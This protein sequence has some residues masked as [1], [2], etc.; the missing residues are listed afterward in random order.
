MKNLIKY[1]LLTIIFFVGGIVFYSCTDFEKD[2]EAELVKYAEITITDFTPKSGRPGQAVTITGSNFGEYSDAAKVYF[3]GVLATEIE[4]YTNNQMVVRVPNDAGTGLISVNVWTHVKDFIDEFTYI[5]GAKISSIS[6]SEGDVGDE[7]T[8]TGESFGTESSLVTIYFGGEVE[9][10][11]VSITDTEIVVKVPDGGIRG[12][13]TMEIGPQILTG[14]IFSYPFVGLN[15]DFNTDGESEGWV[16]SNNSTNEV[17]GGTMNVLYDM[18]ATKRRADFKLEGGA[19][20]HAGQF[21]IVAIR[22]INKPS[23]GNFIFDT[24]LGKYKDG[25]NNWEGILFGDIY[26]YDL[27]NTFGSGATLSTTEPTQLTTFQWK[28]ADITSDETGYSVDWVKTFENVDKLIEYANPPEGKYVFEFNDNPRTVTYD[29]LD[30][31]IGRHNATTIIEDDYAKVTFDPAQFEGD[32]KRRSDFTWS[33]AGGWGEPTQDFDKP[34]W[35]VSADYP[36]YAIKIYFVQADGTLGGPRPAN[37]KIFYDRLGDF[38]DDYVAENVLFLDATDW[39]GGEAK[40]E[41]DAWWSIKVPDIVSD[42][43]GYWV[44]WHRTF[45]NI[46]ELESFLGL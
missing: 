13:I 30:D 35:V 45:K 31:W 17:L 40:K 12:E 20:V 23:T 6:P 39:L 16:T 43:Q 34:A 22:M 37:G 24:N 32:N 8:I 4:S 10:E 41:V 25:S 5:P 1:I 9:A 36:I 46:E 2:Y 26:Y 18:S 21:P 11:I 28:V 42:E 44:D 7:I 3:N 38:S 15:F 29:V 14:P 33:M 27:R 19:E